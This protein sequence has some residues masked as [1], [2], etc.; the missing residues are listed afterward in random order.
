MIVDFIAERQ[1][2]RPKSGQIRDSVESFLRLAIFDD[3]L[4]RS[5]V[6]AMKMAVAIGGRRAADRAGPTEQSD[7]KASTELTRFFRK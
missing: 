1:D 4:F 5:V 7:T 2:A 6:G 3:D